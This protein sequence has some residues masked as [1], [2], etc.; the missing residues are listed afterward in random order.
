MIPTTMRYDA[1]LTGEYYLRE[2]ITGI[3][4][5]E[6][7]DTVAMSAD[8]KIVAPN[9]LYDNL[10]GIKCGMD[11]DILGTPF[12]KLEQEYLLKPGVI[13]SVTASDGNNVELDITVY[14]KTIYMAKSEDEYIFDEGTTATDR[15][16]AIAS[17]W[18]IPLGTIA[19]T[20]VKLAQ[21]VNRKKNIWSIIQDS[22]KETAKKGG[23]M[24]RLRMDEKGLEL[25]KLGSNTDIW[26]LEYDRGETG[27]TKRNTLDNAVTKVKVLGNAS[28]ND[29]SPILNVYTQD[30]DKYGTLQK[31]FD[32]KKAIDEGTAETSAK[33]LFSV[34]TDD[35]TVN[36][37]DI[38]TIRAGDIVR[39]EDFED[40]DY[41]VTDVQHQL[42]NPGS[43]SLT[44]LTKEAVKN[45][46]YAQ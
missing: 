6:S 26:M 44:L 46:Y 32:D 41:Y 37:I 24:Y 40:I 31:I 35:L 23:E 8:I 15:I 30:T 29:R 45:K 25:V 20:G 43:M 2:L 28:N 33:A 13:W 3:T 19:D 22:L 16:K 39:V 21:S 14:D 38:N 36:H 7:L 11:M 12:G 27:L 9:N 17:D 1:V 34:P 10:P 4:L 18:N 42:G 5:S